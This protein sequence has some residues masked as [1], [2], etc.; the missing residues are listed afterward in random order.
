MCI[1]PSSKSNEV[2]KL[3]QDIVGRLPELAP[4]SNFLTVTLMNINSVC[5]SHGV[6]GTVLCNE[7][8][9]ECFNAF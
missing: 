7:T 8:M 2:L 6:I 5:A 3:M 1:S 9:I 4:A